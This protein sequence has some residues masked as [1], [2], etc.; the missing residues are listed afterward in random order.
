VRN[1][2]ETFSD[3]KQGN[4]RVGGQRSE[5]RRKIE[6]EELGRGIGGSH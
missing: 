4:Q 5:V 2:T 3:E 1:F 6:K